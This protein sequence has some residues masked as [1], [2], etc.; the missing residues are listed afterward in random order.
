M[1]NRKESELVPNLQEKD[2]PDQPALPDTY[3]Q[4]WAMSEKEKLARAS[5]NPA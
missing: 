5:L 4:T 1:V 2:K 3:G